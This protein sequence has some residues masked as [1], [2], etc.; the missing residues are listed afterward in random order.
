MPVYLL[1]SAF[2]LWMAV[3]CVRH[4]RTGQWLWIIL[5]FG[6][7]GAA[8]YFFSEFQPVRWTGSSRRKVSAGELRRAEADAR[9]LETAGA[10]GHLASLQRIRGD[11]AKAVA[12]ASRAV[13]RSPQA[14]EAHYELGLA[15]LGAKQ[16][17]LA[18]PHLLQVVEMDAFHDAGD[19]L[20]ALAE[21]ER[22]SADL[23]SARAHYELLSQR[24]ARPEI[25]Y[26]LAAT[27]ACLGD[28]E[29]AASTLRRL[30]EEAE[31]VPDYLRRR[32]SPW[33]RKARRALR[34]LEA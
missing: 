16:P 5:L 33:T 26:A 18:V 20:F 9:R 27:Q 14:I 1:M 4:G 22:A 32:V 30:I 25:L 3:D 15:Q 31:F 13:E 7:M 34:Q 24:H 17:A 29:S 10:W 12:A 19:A 8:V 28:R 11:F 6:P 21:A 2:T 23:A